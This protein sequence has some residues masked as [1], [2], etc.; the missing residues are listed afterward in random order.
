MKTNRHFVAF[1]FFGGFSQK[2]PGRAPDQG[3][4]KRPPRSHMKCTHALINAV[5]RSH[6]QPAF[7]HRFG[8]GPQLY[9]VLVTSNATCR[10]ELDHTKE[11]SNP[12]QL[13]VPESQVLR[14]YCSHQIEPSPITVFGSANCSS[15][16]DGCIGRV[17]VVMD[18]CS[19]HRI[20]VFLPH[21][22][23]GPGHFISLVCSSLMSYLFPLPYPSQGEEYDLP[24]LSSCQTQ[25]KEEGQHTRSAF[26][27]H[28]LG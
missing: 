25:S 13:K 7:L 17:T 22:V 10:I 5:T 3:S 12:S 1:S 4:E 20:R 23:V 19:H 24:R 6:L 28:F 11:V 9:M 26:P 16:D 2:C 14:L 21:P 18:I 15:D 27:D 8:C